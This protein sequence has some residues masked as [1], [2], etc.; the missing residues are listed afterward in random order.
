MMEQKA[1]WKE[2]IREIRLAQRANRLVLFVG[3]GVSANSGV[4]TWEN[5]IR[6]IAAEIGY[7]NCHRCKKNQDGCSRKDCSYRF[8]FSSQDF[9]RIPDYFSDTFGEERQSEYLEFLQN[10]L[11][12]KNAKPN[13][14][15]EEIFRIMPHHII[16][17]NFDNL[18]ENTSVSNRGLFDV[19]HQ[20]GDLLKYPNDKYI[21]KMHGDFSC[22]DSIVLREGDYLEYENTHPLIS[23]FIRSLL[24]NHTFVFLGYGLNDY[25]LNLIIS[26]INYFRKTTNTPGTIRNYLITDKVP[27]SFE[28]RRLERQGIIVVSL[29]DLP[30]ELVAAAPDSITDPRGRQLYAFVKSI[31]TPSIEE[32]VLT[33][34]E[35]LT[36]KYQDFSQYQKIAVSDFLGAHNFRDAKIR[37]TRMEISDVRE[38]ENLQHLLRESSLIREVFQKVG[39]QTVVCTH[40]EKEHEILQVDS[41]KFL[42]NPLFRLE[43]DNDYILLKRKVQEQ[44][45]LFEKMYYCRLCGY[46]AQKLAEKTENQVIRDPALTLLN[47]IRAYYGWGRHSDQAQQKEE[48]INTIFRSLPVQKDYSVRFLR[49]LFEYPSQNRNKMEG[50]L[51]KM[52]QSL[53]Q[54]SQGFSLHKAL[55]H[56]ELLRSYAYDYYFYLKSNL[57]PL[58]L[59]KDSSDYLRP[60]LR[61]LISISRRDLP[62]T[63]D[64]EWDSQNGI[65]YSLNEID[66]DLLSKFGEPHWLRRTFNFY[67]TD[68]LNIENGISLRKKAANLMKS[69]LK[70]FPVPI[71]WTAQLYLL[72]IISFH[73]NMSNFAKSQLFL[74]LSHLFISTNEP[75]IRKSLIDTLKYALRKI[76]RSN[77]LDLYQKSIE[78]LQSFL[79]TRLS[80]KE[81]EKIDPVHFSSLVKALAP[82]SSYQ[83]NQLSEMISSSPDCRKKTDRIERYYP[84]LAASGIEFRLSELR[85]WI[86]PEQLS[87]MVI[88]GVVIFD[89]QE[90][91]ELLNWLNQ[92]DQLEKRNRW[93]KELVRLNLHT[94]LLSRE[95]FRNIPGALSQIGFLVNPEGFDYS[96]VD[97]E[98]PLWQEIIFSNE[99]QGWFKQN[100]KTLLNEMVRFRFKNH[101]QSVMEEKIVYGILLDSEQL[102]CFPN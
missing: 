30:E 96:L 22:R 25:N 26:W 79:I 67:R 87:S 43:L 102:E 66:L 24:I 61:A 23:A 20:D 10:A 100:A 76:D 33:L 83:M 94:D 3:A 89:K 7:D 35:I 82:Y 90:V 5:L 56:F 47:K 2:A 34:K 32:K 1:I 78:R 50:L 46:D 54:T 62:K 72:L 51:H 40:K 75:I 21:I 98:D 55:E 14:I 28:R 59:Y 6:L 57:I 45:S 80:E 48:E 49:Y 101:I 84:A 42:R 60:Y 31:S 38:F 88:D 58:D 95:D 91:S 39:I 93:L 9:I 29:G 85:E 71:H 97:L 63:A 68:I 99:Y 70:E 73:S 37:W 81:L 69:M 11:R 15:N 86:K 8:E 77:H 17:T 36:E 53:D 16:T 44:G 4:P 13:P 64:L 41:A 19:I 74:D 52:D 27:V 12:L 18:L 65:L 92:L